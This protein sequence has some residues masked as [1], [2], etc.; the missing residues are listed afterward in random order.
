MPQALRRSGSG[1]DAGAPLCRA[2]QEED[3]GGRHRHA[4]ESGFRRRQ[5]VTGIRFTGCTA[6]ITLRVTPRPVPMPVRAVPLPSLHGIPRAYQ[7]FHTPAGSLSFR[8]F[9]RA[10]FPPYPCAARACRTLPPAP[11]TARAVPARKGWHLFSLPG[12]SGR[13]KAPRFPRL[14]RAREGVLPLREKRGDLPL[15]GAFFTPLSVNKKGI[16]G[17]GLILSV[18]EV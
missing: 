18:R 7:D 15:S 12:S 17:G 10:A 13:E 14:R 4:S 1:S 6:R 5:G 8:P 9:R 16:K 3:H 2:L 11:G